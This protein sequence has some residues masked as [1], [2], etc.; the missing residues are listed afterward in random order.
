MLEPNYELIYQLRPDILLTFIHSLFCCEWLQKNEKHSP[1]CVSSSL[2]FSSYSTLFGWMITLQGHDF[3]LIAERLLKFFS[4]LLDDSRLI[5]QIFSLLKKSFWKSA[6]LFCSPLGRAQAYRLRVRRPIA[7]RDI[8]TACHWLNQLAWRNGRGQQHCRPKSEDHSAQMFD[9]S[10]DQWA[11]SFEESPHH[12]AQNEVVWSSFRASKQHAGSYKQALIQITIFVLIISEISD[13]LATV[14]LI[15]SMILLISSTILIQK[16]CNEHC[17]K[18]IQ[19]STSVFTRIIY[20]SCEL[21]FC[22]NS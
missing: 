16:N 3:T 15:V 6:P 10:T 14:W 19:S 1:H 9:W 4:M 8:Q 22:F 11:F 17:S 12:N 7:T 2:N 21:N 5:T 13:H 20:S 18:K